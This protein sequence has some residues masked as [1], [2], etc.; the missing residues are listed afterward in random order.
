L[1]S[2]QLQ[3]EFSLLSQ[4]GTLAKYGPPYL[5][6]ANGPNSRPSPAAGSSKGSGFFSFGGSKE[7][8]KDPQFAGY[9]WEK[10]KVEESPINSYLFSRFVSLSSFSLSC[11]LKADFL[12]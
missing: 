5:P 9:V 7:A 8:K 10:E 3:H 6:H 12:L 11:K 4:I 1:S 2:L